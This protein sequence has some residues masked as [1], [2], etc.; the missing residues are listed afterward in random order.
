MVGTIC[1][2]GDGTRSVGLRF[3]DAS[4]FLLG[5]VIGSAVLGLTTAAGGEVLVRPFIGSTTAIV[6]AASVAALAALI[7]LRIPGAR[8]SPF[9]RQ[10][11]AALFDVYRRPIVAL[12]WG[13]EQ[14]FGLLTHVNWAGLYV[15]LAA[16]VLLG[17]PFGLIILAAYGFVRG[18]QPLVML[19]LSEA[20]SRSDEY[21]NEFSR[22][23]PDFGTLRTASLF[24]A[25]ALPLGAVLA[26][27][28]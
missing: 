17:L 26:G 18:A 10:V 21:F 25:I 6:T 7:D 27:A 13:A 4:T 11:N 14:G 2:V 15:A 8:I 23:Y 1:P 24:C 3:L 22:R 9:P 19:A 28:T 5:C 16:A 20:G 12:R